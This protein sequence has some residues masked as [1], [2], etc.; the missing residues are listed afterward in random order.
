MRRIDPTNPTRWLARELAVL[1]AQSLRPEPDRE[2]LAGYALGPLSV[3]HATAALDALATFHAVSGCLDVLSG[4]RR[5]FAAID[6]ACLYR[7]WDVR[8]LVALYDRNP[9]PDRQG[10]ALMDVIATCWMHAEAIGATRLRARLDRLVTRVVDG[11]PGIVGRNMSPLCTLV[12]HLAT[13]RD[14]VQL[15]AAG[16][17]PIGVYAPVVAGTFRACD[18]DTLATFHQHAV[19]TKRWPPFGAYPYRVVPVELLAIARRTGI[20]IEGRHP[21]L[22]TTLARQ[23]TVPDIA[24]PDELRPVIERATQELSLD[25]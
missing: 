21:L 8:L 5:G 24:I 16:W 10:N 18:Y 4:H 23:R 3:G 2:A 7:Y 13:G 20:P 12:A 17:A 15:E 19:D 1:R 14:V 11:C 22:K 6:R 25:P 9:R